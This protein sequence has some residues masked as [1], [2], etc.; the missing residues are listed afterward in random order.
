[1]K[2]GYGFFL[3]AATSVAILGMAA[4]PPLF[5]DDAPKK[6]RDEMVL[7][8][9]AALSGSAHWIYNDLDEAFTAAKR[10]GKPLMVVHR[11]IP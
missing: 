6:T 5:A 8:D 7:D 4:K 3:S 1:M 2:Q 11:C 10:A 9:R